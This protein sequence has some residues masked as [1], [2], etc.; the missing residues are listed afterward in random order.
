MLYSASAI[1]IA[2]IPLLKG[3]DSD[4]NYD[5]TCK[6]SIFPKSVHHCQYKLTLNSL[7]RTDSSASPVIFT[8]LEPASVL[9]S[10]C[11]AMTQGLF[12]RLPKT[13]LA[14][15]F[16]LSFTRASKL[17]SRSQPAAKGPWASLDNRF[18][19]KSQL[20]WKEEHEMT[21]AVG[22]VRGEYEL[23]E[24]RDLV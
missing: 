9:I 4:S 2:R 5:S 20:G 19:S 23:T 11:M 8:V 12:K 22:T 17:S 10:T 16:S 1:S 6:S 14:S 7:I 21:R 15:M 3:A 13:K 18:G 24:P